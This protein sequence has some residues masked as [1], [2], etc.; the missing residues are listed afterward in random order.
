MSLEASAMGVVGRCASIGIFGEGRCGPSRSSIAW[1]K[2]NRTCLRIGRRGCLVGLLDGSGVSREVHAPFC[3]GLRVRFSWST[4]LTKLALVHR[5]VY[6]SLYV[7]MDLFSRFVVARM[8]SKKENNALSK[9]LMNEAT[10]RYAIAPGQLTLDQDR[11]SP[12]TAHGY[13]ENMIE[14]DITCSHSRPRVSN[15]N[16][17]SE[18]QF[19]TQNTNRTTR[20]AS[21]TLR[22]PAAAG[23]RTISAGT[24][25][26]T[27]I[28]GFPA[29]PVSRC[30]PVAIKASLSKISAC[31]TI[32]TSRRQHASSKVVLRSKCRRTLL[33]S[34]PSPPTMMVKPLLIVWTFRQSQQP[35]MGLTNRGYL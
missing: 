14:L 9:Q 17:F 12:M 11:G 2:G 28:T 7:E 20:A 5:G 29:I 15:D 27:I 8:L 31:W 22:I 23:M 6:L 25:M 1:S 26:S 4:L 35:A 3:E 34:T 13:L 32:A 24:T 30:S 19:K 21:K 10:A 33:P 18:S 16:P